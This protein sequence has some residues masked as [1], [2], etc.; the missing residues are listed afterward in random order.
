MEVA[1]AFFKAFQVIDMS[2]LG[3]NGWESESDIVMVK[4]SVIVG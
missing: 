1:S 2:T 4:A 3:L